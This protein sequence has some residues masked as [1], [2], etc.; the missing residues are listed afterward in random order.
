[1]RSKPSPR[2]HQLPTH[3]IPA[4]NGVANVSLVNGGTRLRV[5]YDD[6]DTP[7]ADLEMPLVAGPTGPQGPPGADGKDG[8]LTSFRAFARLDLHRPSSIKHVCDFQAPLA[9]RET[10]APRAIIACSQLA[11]N[12]HT[13]AHAHM[14]PGRDGRCSRAG[15]CSWSP[16]PPGARRSPGACRWPGSCWSPGARR[17]KRRGRGAR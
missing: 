9:I 8:A 14:R 15:G 11:P 10:Q 3:P 16:R 2:H 13:R 7:P 5:T 4:A 17:R 12:L 6:P 1:M